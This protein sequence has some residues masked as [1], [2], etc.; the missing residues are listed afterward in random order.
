MIYLKFDA[1]PSRKPGVSERV[2]QKEL[3]ER[4]DK[5]HPAHKKLILERDEILCLD[6]FAESGCIYDYASSI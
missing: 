2:T 1:G 3:E 4:G 6:G 5:H